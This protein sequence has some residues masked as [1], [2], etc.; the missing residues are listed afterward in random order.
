LLIAAGAAALAAG[1]PDLLAALRAL[2]GPRSRTARALV[3]VCAVVLLAEAPTWFAPPVHGDQTKYHLVYPRLYALA[4]ALVATPWDIWGQ[5]QW[6][7]G[8]LFAIGYALRGEDLA[9][10]LNGV[11]GVMAA[12][13]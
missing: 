10:L 9:R 7:E 8:F 6:L 13:A 1:G 3:A 5:Q 4:G 11:S 2:R 12:L